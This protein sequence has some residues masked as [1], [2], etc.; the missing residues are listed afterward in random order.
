[1]WVVQEV[2]SASNVYIQCGRCSVTWTDFLRAVSYLH[3]TNNS[4]VKDIARVIGLQQIRMA[5]DRGMR[6]PLQDLIYEC[7]HRRST[8]ARDKIYALLGLMGDPMSAFLRPDYSKSV[9]EVYANVARHLITQTRSL[10]PI[11]GQQAQGRLED[12]PSWVP[13]FALDQNLT[14]TPL[15][16]VAGNKSIFFASGRDERSKYSLTQNNEDWHL[17]SA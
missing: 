7:R 2:G 11:C 13:D 12:L 17:L 1:M 10:N 3:F 16:A 9:N 6:A 15:V 5:W 14:P 8:D 4:P